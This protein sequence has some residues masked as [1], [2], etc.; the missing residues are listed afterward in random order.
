MIPICH[1]ALLVCNITTLCVHF[2][3]KIG[4]TFSSKMWVHLSSIWCQAL[5]WW[6]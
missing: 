6:R 2:R 4:E 5:A 3:M 1:T